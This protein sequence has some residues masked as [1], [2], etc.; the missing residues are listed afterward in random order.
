M[1]DALV[2]GLGNPLMGDE[3]I[4]ARVVE[5]LAELLDGTV[6]ADFLDLGTPGFSLIHALRGRRR[7]VLVDCALM[8]EPPGAIRRFTPD[9]VRSFGGGPSPSLH[10]PDLLAV[11]RLARE[12]DECP[13]EIVIFGIQPQRVAPGIGLSPALQARLD[14]YVATVAAELAA[15]RG[16]APAP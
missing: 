14:D 9:G 1:N 4:G 16:A 10:E 7:V 13:P 15:G 8:G 2:A 12:L 5:R 3:G 11:I 6:H